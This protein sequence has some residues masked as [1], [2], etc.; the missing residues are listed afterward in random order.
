MSAS[1]PIAQVSAHSAEH[2]DESYSAGEPG[3]PK[4]L[5]RTI[6]I[7]MIEMAL[8]P[9]K[10]EVKRS[11][12]M[13]FVIRNAGKEDHEFLLATTAEILKHAETVRKQPDM[14]H[15]DAIGVRVAP[16]KSAVILWHFTKGKIR[17]FL[18]DP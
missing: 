16:I 13:R 4:K 12:Q 15:D 5:A 3:D 14:Q 17:I 8:A 9:F 2:H 11:E 6:E 1:T 10:I 7:A 18:P